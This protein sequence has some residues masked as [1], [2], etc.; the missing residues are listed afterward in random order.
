MA[1]GRKK[2]GKLSGEE[3]GGKVTRSGKRKLMGVYYRAHGEKK[4]IKKRKKKGHWSSGAKRKWQGDGFAGS[5]KEEDEL[6]KDRWDLILKRQEVEGISHE[7]QR[8]EERGG[9][10]T[11]LNRAALGRLPFEGKKCRARKNEK[12]MGNRT[13]GRGKKVVCGWVHGR[14]GR[15]QSKKETRRKTS[16]I[17]TT[18]RKG[19][20]WS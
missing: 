8:R 6:K 15:C 3:S 17:A 10:G 20:E 9:S 2:D 4:G 14:R 13:E 19:K 12:I 16:L 11:G 1:R 18:R 7:G 5:F